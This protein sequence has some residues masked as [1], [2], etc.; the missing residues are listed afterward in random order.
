MNLTFTATDFLFTLLLSGL[1]SSFVFF[2]SLIPCHKDTTFPST[3]Q[4]RPRGHDHRRRPICVKSV[5]MGPIVVVHPQLPRE[6]H[7][8]HFSQ[9]VALDTP[10]FSQHLGLPACGFCHSACAIV[11]RGTG[12]TTAAGFCFSSFFLLIC[13]IL[14]FLLKNLVSSKNWNAL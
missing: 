2:L 3:T 10:G 9:G 13:P 11:F 4:R 12:A 6:R 14:E 1:S 5:H 8:Q 7:E